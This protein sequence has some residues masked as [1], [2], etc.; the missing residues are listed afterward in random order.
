GAHPPQHPVRAGPQVG[1][2]AS[3][4]GQPHVALAQQHLVV[5]QREQVTQVAEMAERTGGAAGDHD[6][7]HPALAQR[8]Q[9][10]QHAFERLVGGVDQRAVQ[11]QGGEADRHRRAE[12]K[13]WKSCS[14]TA[15]VA[16]R[17]G[18]LNKNAHTSSTTPAYPSA[19]TAAATRIA[20]ASAPAAFGL[21]STS[22]RISSD[23]RESSTESASMRRKP[24]LRSPRYDT[25]PFGPAATVVASMPAADSA[26]RFDF[27]L[28][29]DRF[30]SAR[31]GKSV[32]PPTLS[33]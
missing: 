7:Q 2:R 13:V 18:L 30:G 8:R 3:G 21:S 9:P 23:S 6:R 1:Q 17:R 14:P 15:S 29:A 24:T 28:L 22:I 19:R 31:L 4:A 26:R 10:G 32:L 33:W 27:C 12:T 5:G 25:K 11:V 16:G 20:L